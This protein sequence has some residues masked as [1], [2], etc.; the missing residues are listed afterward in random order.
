MATL[1]VYVVLPGL[2]A[3]PVIALDVIA[4][5]AVPKQSL[6]AAVAGHCE[7]SEAISFSVAKRRFGLASMLTQRRL[8]PTCDPRLEKLALFK[9]LRC[10]VSCLC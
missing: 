10:P 5:H 1:P 9:I 7:R 8:R 4:R 6:V 3:K 2:L